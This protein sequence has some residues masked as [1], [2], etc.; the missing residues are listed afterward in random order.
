M[1][2]KKR[3]I[4]T[5]TF[6]IYTKF[7]IPWHLYVI[8]TI[9]GF[10]SAKVV[11][12][13]MSYYAEIQ[14]G[15]ITDN[16]VVR[17]YFLFTIANFVIST[18][19]TIP[20]FYASNM[21]ARN[22]KSSLLNKLISLPIKEFDDKSNKFISYISR[23]TSYVNGLITTII[24]FFTGSFTALITTDAMSDLT[25]SLNFILPAVFLYSLVA[26]YFVG[27]LMFKREALSRQAESEITAY[28]SEHLGYFANIKQ[29]HALEDEIKN[30]DEAIENV[31][32]AEVK[33]SLYTLSGN[34]I[35]GSMTSIIQILV[36]VLGVPLVRQGQLDI[37]EL[38]TYQ[39][40]IIVA[41]QSLSSLP[42]LYTMLK[43]Y[44]GQLV[45]ISSVYDLESEDLS[46]GERLSS[47]DLD[48]TFENVS[49][50]YDEK[51]VLTNKS[52]TIPAGKVTCLIGPNGSGKST[53]I[54][55]IERFYQ[56]NDGMIKL[57]ETD[58]N[59]INLAQYRQNIGYVGQNTMLFN[60]T[61]R[62]NVNF[63]SERT[64]ADDEI[65]AAL[66]FAKADGF[67]RE[68]PEGLDYVIG[69]QGNK[70]SGGQR[71]R[72]AI[73]RAMVIDP[74]ILI[75]DEATSN[76]DAQSAA[77]VL[78]AVRALMK[79]RTTIMVT[80]DQTMFSYCDHYVTFG[81][82]EED[83]NQVIELMTSK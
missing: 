82:N 14:T 68:K 29:Q 70:L 13:Y 49:F 34:I 81:Q 42:D 62:A 32:K 16:A 23:D 58:I 36:F 75:L 20:S 24:G 64:L 17:G 63:G 56:P 9:L 11:I 74:A 77:E 76:I 27:K 73:A 22:A 19:S 35:D 10:V 72:L 44:Q 8:E 30:S 48:L 15:N 51:E 45:N 43:Y 26:T 41:Y 38:V 67:V 4:W 31:Y 37:S 46:A 60:D 83:V 39:N 3:N 80:H 53:T 54:K 6:R 28:Y 18:L 40:L 12:E 47:S 71:Q 7:K 5:S 33:V 50:G 25:G 61:I 57:G 52:F 1:K 66:R 59:D 55:L 65:W 21:V 78:E 79:D 2:E 69:D